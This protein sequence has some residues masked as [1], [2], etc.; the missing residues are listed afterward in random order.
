MAVLVASGGG[1]ALARLLW[2]ICLARVADGLVAPAGP[3][4]LAG[5]RAPAPRAAPQTEELPQTAADDPPGRP[6][7]ELTLGVVRENLTGENRVS[8]TPASA[9]ALIKAGWRVA[10][11]SGAGLRA[12]F[13]D[14]DFVKAGCAVVPAEDAWLADVVA[15]VNPPTAD[16]AARVGSRAVVALLAPAQN[17]ELLDQLAAQ[18]ATAFAMDCVPRTL[19][20]AQA[21]DVL[22]SQANLAGFRA[23]IEAAHAFGRT[24]APSMTAAGKLAPA[25]VLVLGAGVAGLA[26]MQTAKNMGAQV[27]GYDVRAVCR[28]Q[29]ESMGGKFL[30][31]PFVED[32]AGQGGYA[33]EMSDGYKKAEQEML[34][35]EVAAADILITTALIPGRPAP[36]LVSEAM[37]LAMRRGAVVVDMASVNGGNVALT[38]DGAETVTPNGVT[39]LGYSDLPSRLAAAASTL[40]GNNVAKFLLAVGPFTGAPGRFHVDLE[41]PATRAML[42]IQDGKLTW[43]SPPYVP[44][45]G[46]APPPPPPAVVAAPPAKMVK[47]KGGKPPA[48]ETKLDPKLLLGAAALVL[49]AGAASGDSPEAASLFAVFCLSS[50]AG[51]QVVWG[52]APALHSPLMAVTNAISGITALGGV[53]LLEPGHVVPESPTEALGAVAVLISAVNIAGG[54]RVTFKTLDLF[55][56][57]KKAPEGPTLLESA[58][59]A[60]GL[61]TLGTVGL[62]VG[63]VGAMPD[64]AAAAAATLCV[65]SIGGLAS[66]QTAEAGALAGLAGVA[67]GTAAA[68]SAVLQSGELGPLSALPEVALVAGLLAAG[69]GAGYAIAGKVGPTQLPQTVAAFHSL[70]GLAAVLTA[71]G[72]FIGERGGMGGGAVV[73][74]GAATIIGAVTLTGSLVAFAKLAELVPSTP[75]QKSDAG[76]AALLAVAVIGTAV[77]ALDPTADVAPAALGAVAVAS[78]LLGLTL[79]SS[80]GGA[81]MPVVITVLNS[82]SGWALCAEGVLLNDALLTSVGAL[83]GFS[84]AILTKIMC[85]AMNR[86]ILNV[87]LG[88]GPV[89]AAPKGAGGAAVAAPPHVE[90]DA[91]EAAQLL[92][93]AE[94]VIIVPGYG[95]AVAKAQYAVAELA[96]LLV[97]NGKRV[98]F[99]VHPV[100]G[101]MPGQLNVLLAEADVPYETVEEMEEINADF[102]ETDVAIVVGASDTVNAGAVEDPSSPIAGMPVLRVWDAKRT[103]AFK[104]SMSSTGYAGVGNPT[105]YKPGTAMLLGDAKDT[106]T[107][108][109]A[110]LRK[111]V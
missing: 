47:A 34:L 107:E 52:V 8:Q 91:A 109:L 76:N 87:I 108:L 92:F 54:F 40:Y 7:S 97:A 25:R 12:G 105:F 84:G 41:D 82:Y 86:N 24:F 9:A 39:I 67:L 35:A 50:F 16:E 103:I 1:R 33:K 64:V 3:R 68:L 69:G 30:E 29:V 31:V 23:I 18:G 27:Y 65:A 71:G 73:A 100:A 70:V 49:A 53:A 79:V 81:D 56:G 10:V 55:K 60:L 89:A 20:R 104:R 102:A 37:V 101:R 28:E 14:D 77:M 72:E 66:Q 99:G 6:Y 61:A 94:S 45:Q 51:Q 80:V 110:E 74:T 58:A 88:G 43:P 15:K 78:S 59:P 5:R 83:I 96:A 90:V 44:P 63:G 106:A 13:G 2:C 98:R 93:D 26:A 42:V 4:A 21:F 75:A 57:S 48:A 36:L 17:G 111:L 11:E 46:A 38:V 85:D 32:G 95:L 62:S 19:S 22:S